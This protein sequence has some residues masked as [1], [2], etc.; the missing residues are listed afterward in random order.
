MLRIEQEREKIARAK[1]IIKTTDSLYLKRDLKKYIKRAERQIKQAFF[2][3]RRRAECREEHTPT[4]SQ[5]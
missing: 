1:E 2:D 3:E 4:A 5:T